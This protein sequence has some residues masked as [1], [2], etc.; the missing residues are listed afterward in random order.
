MPVCR[1]LEDA[2]QLSNK[3]G[4]GGRH[5]EGVFFNQPPYLYSL[6]RRY[7]RRMY[8]RDEIENRTHFPLSCAKVP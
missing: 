1:N 4:D 6:V 7:R 5:M 8:E 2:Q 3:A